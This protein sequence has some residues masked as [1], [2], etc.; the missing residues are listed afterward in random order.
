M[1]SSIGNYLVRDIKDI[2]Y[3]DILIIDG[4]YKY[5]E[6]SYDRS[7]YETF[8]LAE[9]LNA[10]KVY[11]KIIREEDL[12]FFYVKFFRGFIFYHVENTNFIINFIDQ[13]NYFNKVIFTINKDKLIRSKSKNLELNIQT[14]FIPDR[15][16]KSTTSKSS[17]I[18]KTIDLLF[19][20]RN[21]HDN[22]YLHQKLNTLSNAII[23][24]RKSV[25]VIS[26]IYDKTDLK[27][28]L[29]LSEYVE[30][31]YYKDIEDKASIIKSSRKVLISPK[32][33][34]DNLILAIE[35]K[36]CGTECNYTRYSSLL[37]N[38]DEIILQFSTL[39]SKSRVFLDI[40]DYLNQLVVFNVA[41]TAIRGGMNVI[42]KH[43]N[44]LRDNG[45]DVALLTDQ[46]E[47]KNII[48]KDGELNV[49]S[50]ANRSIAVNIDKLI[51]TLWVTAYYVEEYANAKEKY[52]LV[53]GFETDFSEVGDPWRLLA[54]NTYRSNNLNYVTVSKWCQNWL[55][56]SYDQDSRYCPNGL[57]KKLFAYKEKKFD[58]KIRVLIEGSCLDDYKNVDESFHIVK[59]LDR[60]K[61][62][63]WYLTYD[64][65]PKSWYDYD[66][67]FFKV[68]YEE[69]ASIY[70]SCHI[71]LKSSKLE[72]FSYPPLEMMATGGIAVVARNQGNKEYAI[73]R[74]NS[75]VYKV[76]QIKK[77][78]SYIYEIIENK[79]LRDI[80]IKNGVMLSESRSW[81]NINN[82]II[83][84]YA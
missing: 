48:N 60:N 5:S 44:V 52:Y 12:V 42:I 68:P 21:D 55:K 4:S 18:N 13:I 14:L 64:G 82:K 59:T 70:Q 22:Q 67:L 6:I 65:N 66:K 29:Y 71:L 80:I 62:E 47:E 28:P 24:K 83:D 56:N 25:G 69:V 72:S 16:I 17:K 77:A 41:G 10:N 32:E 36:L 23:S 20:V 33:N 43:A 2:D 40:L 49:L 73:H 9:Y 27:I 31:H 75:M 26:N 37:K 39:Y 79:E 74:K 1:Y 51:A 8:G 7:Y 53:Q 11:T 54:N 84:L 57:N 35:C 58:G 3:N 34:A 50:R 30:V 19:I 38:K 78:R 15:V 61:F 46:D 45:Y 63:I 81:D 76:G